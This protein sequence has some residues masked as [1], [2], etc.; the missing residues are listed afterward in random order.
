MTRRNVTQQQNQKQNKKQI[1]KIAAEYLPIK[2]SI[3]NK[4]S[5]K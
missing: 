4:D 2:I 5:E 3:R 1:N